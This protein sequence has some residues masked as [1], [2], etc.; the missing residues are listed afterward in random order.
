[1]L[2][3]VAL[4][5]LL[6][7]L[8]PVLAKAQQSKSTSGAHPFRTT[9]AL[10]DGG[11]VVHSSTHQ[12]QRE[13]RLIVQFEG[14][15]LLGTPKSLNKG[16]ENRSLMATQ[17][18][19][20][21]DLPRIASALGFSNRKL[22]VER[23]YSSIYNGVS[24]TVPRGAVPSIRQLPYVK[25]V[26]EDGKIQVASGV[27]TSARQVTPFYRDDD[28]AYTGAGIVVAVID[29]GVDYTHPALGGGF[30][31]GYKVTDGYDFVDD[32][33][34]PMDHHGHGTHV[35]GIIAGSEPYMKGMA[36]GAEVMALRVLDQN[37]I[38]FDSDVIAALEYA[39]NPDGNPMTDDAVEVANL[40]L[41]GLKSG[42]M[43][44]PVTVAVERA[45]EAGVICVV[46]AGNRGEDGRASITVPGNAPTAITVGASDGEDTIAPFSSQ[47]PS[48]TIQSP[49]LPHFGLKPDLVAP[50]VGI[51]STWL[52]GAYQVLD[53]T[54]MASPYVA[55]LAARIVQQYPDWSPEMVKA[56]V[57]QSTRDLGSSIW[58]QG[59]GIA[60][61]ETKRTF[62]AYP[63][64]IDFGIISQG[65]EPWAASTSITVINLEL[66]TRQYTISLSGT[67]PAGLSASLSSASVQLAPGEASVV[68]IQL[69]ARPSSIQSLAFPDGYVGYVEVDDGHS[70]VSIPFSFFKPQS[71]QLEIAEPADLV[72]LQGREPANRFTYYEPASQF[73]LFTPPDTYDI[74][75]QFDQ[76]KY[77]VVR[78]AM[79][80]EE[81]IHVN[82]SKEEA[83]RRVSF[84]GV[85]VHGT[86]LNPL[87]YAMVMRNSD[88]EWSIFNEWTHSAEEEGEI[89]IHLSPFSDAYELDF[90]VSGFSE[91]QSYFE[92]PYS[93]GGGMQ[94]DVT[95]ADS[96]EDLVA[97]TYHY[98]L[99]EEIEKARFVPWNVQGVD[100]VGPVLP[101]TQ[102]HPGFLMERPFVKTFLTRP[103]PHDAY[104]WKQFG[105]SITLGT[106]PEED[107][108]SGEAL[109]QVSPLHLDARFAF[110]GFHGERVLPLEEQ[111]RVV[112]VFLHDQGG[113]WVGEL[114]N[115]ATRI[116][117]VGPS[118][119][120]LFKGAWGERRQE[121]VFWTLRNGDGIIEK[122]STTF[123]PAAIPGADRFSSVYSVTPGAYTM[124]FEQ[125][126]ARGAS[127]GHTAVEL[128]FKTDR[129]D[130]DPPRINQFY[131]RIDENDRLTFVFQLTDVCNWC[132]VREAQEQ[133][134][135]LHFYFRFGEEDGWEEANILPG[136]SV[137]TVTLGERGLPLNTVSARIRA[138]DIHGNWMQYTTEVAPS[139]DP[140]GPISV[141]VLDEE[142]GAGPALQVEPL[143]PNPTRDRAWLR[144]RQL[145]DAK[146]MVFVY[147]I[148]GRQVL[149]DEK[150]NRPGSQVH[151]LDLSN[152]PSGVY[153]VQVIAGGLSKA[154]RVV[155]VR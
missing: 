147:D 94:E 1:M 21:S 130:P 85:D 83:S 37:G 148:L 64:S 63:P 82:I 24:I 97:F 74:I 115:T 121:H 23:T 109:V 84:K 146:V 80:V 114:D 118:D 19:F 126:F 76:G 3:V 79:I 26:F 32:D 6:C 132:S 53:G 151:S 46:A 69:Q 77:T 144:Y 145:G 22:V 137:Y 150:N 123:V 133:I 17:A 113:F 40:S 29:T 111:D 122:D 12:D 120:G 103:L 117:I 2:R 44:H 14:E 96:P 36:P 34:D 7:L 106:T 55:G 127:S 59:S 28:T 43:G 152:L 139:T 15:P 73:F 101:A 142:V 92:L 100:I 138:E 107:M 134:D 136:D 60:N 81:S 42:D 20:S 90:K 45:V 18:R 95:F 16:I 104:T 47:G 119:G 108:G 65:Q 124:E 71:A 98:S 52:Y 56:W 129:A 70:P 4:S 131:S 38:G 33:R 72:V 41:S 25:S 57:T 87:S 10:V 62:L 61:E 54:S 68:Q 49:T 140:S 50:G 11:R 13:V 125:Q 78:E 128:G 135:A 110:L 116:R 5:G 99:P 89:S 153:T 91:D 8:V 93:V 143:Y 88:A 31:V 67:L 112:D 154:H 155:K 51:R 149:V 102:L 75:V 35:A 48:G 141:A 39:V 9:L 105:H 30:G 66:E 58:E 86:P 27:G